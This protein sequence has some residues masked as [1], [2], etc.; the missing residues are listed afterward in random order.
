LYPRL[1]P[2]RSRLAYSESQGANTDLWIYELQRGSK[3]RLTSG[4]YNALSVWSADSH[5]LVFQS[6]GGLQWT[7][8]DGASKPQ[9][10][11][12][13]RATLRPYSFIHDGT[14]LV[15]SEAVP[16]GAEI[17]T[18]SVENRSGQLHAG[19]PQVILK[20]ATTNPLPAF[21]PDGKW[22]AYDDAQGGGYEVYVR[23][24]PDNGSRPQISNA[25]GVMPMWSQTQLFYRTEDQRI[26]VVDYTVKAR[27]FS[28]EKPRLW[29]GMKL[30]DT[31]LF[32]N[33]DLANDGKRFI[34][35]LPAQ[36]AEPRERQS[37][38]TVVVNFL[39]EVRQRVA[40]QSK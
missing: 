13:G 7:R 28:S 29:S 2:D 16:G 8:A 1:S 15:F 31:G 23:A 34:A 22:L 5:F 17:R 39:D 38:V 10:L 6:A 9:T 19:E 21:S 3:T 40:G 18:V 12:P 32:V 30:A 27:V 37:H 25:G 35:L 4:G 33:L 14:Q 20:T 24:V 36:A 11:L 26:M